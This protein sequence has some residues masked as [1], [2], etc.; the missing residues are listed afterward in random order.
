MKRIQLA[1]ALIVAFLAFTASAEDIRIGYVDMRKV[2][3]ESK[4][5][6]RV[7]GEIEKAIKQRQDSLSAE[8][9]QLKK[10]QDAYEKD[11]LLL[12]DAQKQA[13]QKEFDEKV[14][15]YQQSTAQAQREI[16][17]K[18]Q[19]FT[20]KALPEIRDIIRDLAK[21]EKLTLVFE[22]HDMPLLYAIDGPDL[23]DKVMQRFDSKNGG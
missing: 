16:D 10:L 21:Q 22:K 12:S 7:K 2:M 15:A 13:K 4:T 11:K 17:Q 23:T 6:K 9:Q 18:Q 1:I 19:E 5:G 3:N 20:G 8:E 14:K